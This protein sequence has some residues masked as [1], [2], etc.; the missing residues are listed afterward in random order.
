MDCSKVKCWQLISLGLLS[1]QILFKCPGALGFKSYSLQIS[2][3]V[4]HCG[5]SGAEH[6]LMV[7]SLLLLA[8]LVVTFKAS[9]KLP[10]TR[11]HFYR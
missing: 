5:G 9:V 3:F 2:K 7:P 6:E 4:L 1:I 11:P 10:G 8:Y